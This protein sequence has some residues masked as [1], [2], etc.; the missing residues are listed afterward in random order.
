[1]S[2]T[3][4]SL[5]AVAEDGPVTNFPEAPAETSPDLVSDALQHLGAKLRTGSTQDIAVA[6]RSVMTS[7]STG[8]ALANATSPAR[9]HVMRGVVSAIVSAVNTSGKA[10]SVGWAAERPDGGWQRAESH[11]VNAGHAPEQAGVES[12]EVLIETVRAL[13]AALREGRVDEAHSQLRRTHG[14][15]DTMTTGLLHALLPSD[16]SRSAA[17]SSVLLDGTSPTV[18]DGSSESIRANALEP[19]LLTP[20]RLGLALLPE[21]DLLNHALRP[22]GM[23]DSAV[24]YAAMHSAGAFPEWKEAGGAAPGGVPLMVAAAGM[25]AL[26]VM[27][28]AF[29][30]T[31]LG[32]ALF[33]AGA[34]WLLRKRTDT[35]GATGRG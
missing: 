2:R 19:A 18:T 7:L 34:W 12:H 24:S 28:L 13:V 11:S 1:S 32:I 27:A 16:P 30:Q 26:A 21:A 20:I 4:V 3:P 15:L 33:G 22:V 23:D 29:R 9:A 25:F 8:G 17:G 5:Q 6:A 31:L 35:A 10:S 14:V